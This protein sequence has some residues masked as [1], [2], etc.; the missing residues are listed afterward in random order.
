M[1]ALQNDPKNQHKKLT[2][3]VESFVV[4]LAYDI[5]GMFDSTIRQGGDQR[6]LFLHADEYSETWS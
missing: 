4:Q 3:S 2:T 6:F 1:Q 5:A